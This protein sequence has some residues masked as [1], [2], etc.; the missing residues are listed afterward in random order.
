MDRVRYLSLAEFRFDALIA[1]HHA[2]INQ[3]EA[4][5]VAGANSAI[6]F[7]LREV[8]NDLPQ[9]V[10]SNAQFFDLPDGDMPPPVNAPIQG[11]TNA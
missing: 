11:G 5:E 6:R 8:L 1:Q 10:A 3:I 9:I 2:I 7:H 4:G